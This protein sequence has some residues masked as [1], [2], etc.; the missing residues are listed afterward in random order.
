MR[1]VL[2]LCV[3]LVCALALG[4]AW[5]ALVEGFSPLDAVYQAV[6]TLSTVGFQ[7]VQPLDTSGQLFTIVYILGGVG[8]LFYTA[9][10]V[11]ETVVVGELAEELGLR[12]SSRKVRRMNQHIVICGYGRVGREVAHELTSRNGTFVII[13]RNEHTLATVDHPGAVVVRGDATEEDTLRAAGIDRAR[14]MIAAADSDV[15]NTYMVLTARALNPSL[16]IVA[17]AGSDSAERRLSSAGADRVISP[18]RIGGRRMALS[19]VQPMLIDFV[20]TLSAGGSANQSGNVLAEIFVG[21]EAAGLAGRTIQDVFAASGGLQVMGIERTGRP[22][23]VGP[24]GDTIITLGDRLMVYG[25]S[26]AVEQF[27]A[28]AGHAR[29]PVAADDAPPTGE[30]QG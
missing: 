2:I 30:T 1:R 6:T 9:T 27:P 7:E 8:L 14:A 10:T 23:Q 5:Y 19:A 28:T 4:S 20:D 11:V 22:L 12:R 29:P 26:D 24:R 15:E 17:R 18:Y 25:D 21:D 13:D 3:L 16:F